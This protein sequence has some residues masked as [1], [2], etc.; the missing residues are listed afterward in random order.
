MAEA[1]DADLA[2]A[3]PSAKLVYYVL[4]Q[5]GKLT[6]SELASETLLPQRTVRDALSRLADRDLVTEG[7]HFMDARKSV[8]SVRAADDVVT[9]PE[10]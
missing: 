6:Q 8:Y 1:P 4:R 5:E 10:E 9:P 3:P 2:E 7:F